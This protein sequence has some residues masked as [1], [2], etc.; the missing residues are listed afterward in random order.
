MRFTARIRTLTTQSLEVPIIANSLSDALKEAGGACNAMR[1]SEVDAVLLGLYDQDGKSL[2][3]AQPDDLPAGWSEVTWRHRFPT[4][5]A[6][7]AACLARITQADP[8]STQTVYEVR[9]ADGLLSK[10]NLEAMS[11]AMH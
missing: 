10:V 1:R 7:E 8:Y 5:D 3:E 2:L 11:S 9:G 6:E 4:V